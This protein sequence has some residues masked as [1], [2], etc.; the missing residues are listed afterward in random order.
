[1]SWDEIV[2]AARALSLDEKVRL[3]H[4]LETGLSHTEATNSGDRSE[5]GVELPAPSWVNYSPREVSPE[6]MAAMQQIF[7]V[8]TKAAS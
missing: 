3:M 7:D 5:S 8:D 6:L 2:A 4:I 1:M